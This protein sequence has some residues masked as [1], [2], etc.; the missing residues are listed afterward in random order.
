MPSYSHRLDRFISKHTGIKRGDVRILLAQGRV[1]V[2]NVIATQGSQTIGQFTRVTL[3]DRILQARDPVYI[4]MNKPA[5]VLSATKDKRHQTVIDLLSRDDREQ[6]HIPGR[7][8]FNSTGLLLLSNDGQWSRQL[9]LPER[10]IS[11]VYTVTLAKPLSSDYIEAFAAG[12]VF[13]YE[14]ITTR[15]AGLKIVSEHVA[16]VTLTEGRYHQIKRMFGRFQNEVLALHRHRIGC[17]E[18]DAGLAPGQSRNLSA[19]E[20][21]SLR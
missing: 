11:K 3:D 8:D 2:D 10:E 14:N 21:E 1:Q 7:L 16:E 13:D 19:A 12:M 18:L 15:P 4:M 17:L 9:S 6:L 5:G 20:V